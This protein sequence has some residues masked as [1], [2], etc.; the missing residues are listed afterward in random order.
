MTDLFD[1]IP[2]IHI[3]NIRAKDIG[4]LVKFDA[5][6]NW[7][8]GNEVTLTQRFRYGT[9]GFRRSTQKSIRGIHPT[10]TYLTY[11]IGEKYEAI[12]ILIRTKRFKIGFY[13]E[14]F[15]LAP[16]KKLEATRKMQGQL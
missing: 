15:G 1:N 10:R 14:L 6:V 5:K 8:K 13:L 16:K 3:N 12:G 9:K 2:K 11:K 7:Q 4:K